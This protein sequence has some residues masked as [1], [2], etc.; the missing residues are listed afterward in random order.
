MR[1]AIIALIFLLLAVPAFAEDDG[2][3]QPDA[4]PTSAEVAQVV[5]AAWK[6]KDGAA[7]QALAASDTPDPWFVA[8]ELC[9]GGHTE[10]AKAF[11]KAAPRA[12]TKALPAFVSAWKSTPDV[13]AVF[14]QAQ[15]LMQTGKLDDALVLLRDAK[16]DNSAYGVGH[17]HLRAVLLATQGKLAD[18]VPFWTDASAR[19]ETLGWI[20]RAAKTALTGA[21]MATQVKDF[22]ALTTLAERAARHYTTLD[23]MD[24]A[25]YARVILGLGY[26][27]AGK[28]AR[29]IA[30][31]EENVRLGDRLQNI[32]VNQ[33]TNMTLAGVYRMVGDYERALRYFRATDAIVRS[34]QRWSDAVNVGTQIGET[35]RLL[36]R[37]EEA[38]VQLRATLKVATEHALVID[39]AR[40]H[41][42]LGDMRLS[43]H[44]AEAEQHLL[45]AQPT[46]EKAKLTYELAQT[47]IKLAK[48]AKDLS[49]SDDAVQLSASALATAE[50]TKE[51]RLI[52]EVLMAYAQICRG[53]GK[54][55][56][57]KQQAEQALIIAEAEGA[58][59]LLVAT[60]DLLAQIQHEAQDLDAAFASWRRMADVHRVEF[61]GL[62]DEEAAKGLEQ[63]A[64]LWT[65][66]VLA[67]VKHQRTQD[68]F[69]LV[70]SARSVALLEA[71]GGA[72]TLGQVE[73]SSAAR[74][75]E[76]AARRAVVAARKALKDARATFKR[77]VVREARKDLVAAWAARL[78]AVERIQRE[79]KAAASMAYPPTP[80]LA[81]TQRSLRKDESVLSYALCG[82]EII[83]LVVTPTA[84]RAVHLGETATAI[85][86][87]TAF[88]EKARSREASAQASPDAMIRTLQKL[89]IEP[90]ELA[91]GVRRV[92]VSPTGQLGY[93]PFSTLLPARDVAYVPSATTL[94]VLRAPDP[95]PGER[96][97]ALGN[98]THDKFRPLPAS[99]QEA[100][101]VGDVVFVGARATEPQLTKAITKEERWRAIH[102]ACH[103]VVDPEQPLLSYLALTADDKS[104]G[105][106]TA[107]EIFSMHIPADLV[108]LSA[109]DTGKGKIYKTEGIVGL[110]RAFMFA[111]APRVICSLWKVDDDA[112]HALMV[113]FYELW[114][115]RPQPGGGEGVKKR[116]NLGVAAALRQAQAHVRSFTTTKDGKQFQPWKHPY[117][118]A[119]WTLW[120]LPD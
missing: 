16:S 117:Y 32:E 55:D 81:A 69:Y 6:S 25:A 7:L 88:V 118:W 11:A 91:S 54:A 57:A 110:T 83:A 62:S 101:T 102:L 77:S 13:R 29:A 65:L 15:A 17:A 92:L 45:H 113:K 41:L 59:W 66:P 82:E 112:T 27:S 116:K 34:R 80:S 75:E 87:A 111:G 18:S 26:M 14:L 37:D 40:L 2:P 12:A 76:A 50:Q 31:L 30:V 3:K 35:L 46:F 33:L 19:A 49:R 97:L 23:N 64:A 119:A 56:E 104:D 96:V 89:L 68:A 106:L 48:A 38:L 47:R 79:A 120:G 63:Y 36:K 58:P 21:Q 39:E 4:P 52:H 84:A 67:A 98:P 60:H 72:Q 114:N 105:Q 43:K 5:L 28:N 8:E 94:D 115:P 10:A 107:L 53:L 44:P 22:S 73:I 71:L 74:A 42:A 78:A 1:E 95:K 9:R 90:L 100:K 93:L 99:E 109:C 24:L 51:P 103:G 108:V 20:E 70:E 85:D 61:T 86:A